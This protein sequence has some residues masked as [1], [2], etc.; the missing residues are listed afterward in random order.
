MILVKLTET[1]SSNLNVL[2]PASL[3]YVASSST[4]NVLDLL[5]SHGHV[6]QNLSAIGSSSQQQVVLT[7]SLARPIVSTNVEYSCMV[8]SEGHTHEGSKGESIVVKTLNGKNKK[9]HDCY[10]IPQN[11]CNIT[12]SNLGE[13]R[14]TK[15]T[16]TDIKKAR[17]AEARSKPPLKTLKSKQPL[18]VSTSAIEHQQYVDKLYLQSFNFEF[19]AG[20]LGGYGAVADKEVELE[21]KSLIST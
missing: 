21:R 1:V 7:E 14:V 6:L 11:S 12:I 10:L 8:S 18:Y 9:R 15:K 16:E 5:K 17:E 2:I 13:K 20:I 4:V 3:T 19:L